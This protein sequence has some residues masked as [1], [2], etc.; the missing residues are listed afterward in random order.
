MPPSQR[1]SL[2]QYRRCKLKLSSQKRLMSL[3]ATL[4]I[5]ETTITRTIEGAAI[6]VSTGVTTAA[7][8]AELIGV[9]VGSSAA[10]AV[11]NIAVVTEVVLGGT[12]SAKKEMTSRLFR[13]LNS[14]ESTEV[15]AEALADEATTAEAEATDVLAILR[16]KATERSA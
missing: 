13:T 12:N 1:S 15:A 6:A 4:T 9:A 8:S 14:S 10:E 3:L 11:V 5:K 7:E 2:K 16:A